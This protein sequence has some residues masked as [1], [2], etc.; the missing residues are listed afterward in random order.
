M[1]SLAATH[2]LSTTADF[3]AMTNNLSCMGMEIAWAWKL[4]RE[5]TAHVRCLLQLVNCTS[6][7]VWLYVWL[8]MP[9]NQCMIQPIQGC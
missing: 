5:L 1:L 4:I 7:H 8:S 6:M 2:N 9:Y 3:I